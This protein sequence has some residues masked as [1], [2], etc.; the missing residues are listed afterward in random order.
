MNFRFKHLC[1]LQDHPSVW[2][3]VESIAL[4]DCYVRTSIR[5]YQLGEAMPRRIRRET[6]ALQRR[7]RNLCERRRDNAVNIVGFLEAIGHNIRFGI[8]HRAQ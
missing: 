7:L 8:N 4:E 1:N 2:T 3:L 6:A 5:Q